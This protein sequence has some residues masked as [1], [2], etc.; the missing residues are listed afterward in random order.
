MH[1]YLSRSI[2]RKMNEA[3]SRGLPDRIARQEVGIVYADLK[4][5]QSVA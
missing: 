3:I 2:A 1:F 5:N 4:S